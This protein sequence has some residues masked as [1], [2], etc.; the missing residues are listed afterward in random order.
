[1]ADQSGPFDYHLTRQLVELCQK[2]AI[3]Y[4]KDVFRHYRSDSASA[5]EA[6]HDIRTALVTFGIDASHGYERIH[7]DALNSVCELLTR[8]VVSPIEIARDVEQFS[9][10]RSFPEQPSA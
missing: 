8:Y 9:D 1:M 5:L 4:R 7:A 6:G 3:E 2:N 10:V